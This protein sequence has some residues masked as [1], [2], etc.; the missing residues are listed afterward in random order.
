MHLVAETA[1][2]ADA[3]QQAARIAPNKGAAFDKAAGILFDFIEVDGTDKLLIRSTNLESTFQRSIPLVERS[4]ET[5]APFRLP[6]A[7]LAAFL[8]TLPLGEGHVTEL[9]LDDRNTVEVKSGKTHAKFRTL[10][11]DDFPAFMIEPDFDKLLLVPDFA[12]RVKQVA[13]CVARDTAPLT[14]IHLDGKGMIACDR[15]RAAQVPCAIPLDHPITAPLSVL[16]GA[17]S[18][19]DEVRLTGIGDRLV[20]VSDADTIVT[21][22]IYPEKYPDIDRLWAQTDA[23]DQ[24]VEFDAKEMLSVLSRILTLCRNE[25]YPVMELTFTAEA[26]LLSMDVEDLGMVDDEVPCTTNFTEAFE[27]RFT[28]TNFVDALGA[29]SSST[30]V[31]QRIPTRPIKLF[32]NDGFSTVMMPRRK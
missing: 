21:S 23:C 29:M 26:M 22:T 31:F 3:V 15:S 4:L 10:N 18:A 17:L 30:L 14:G 12:R 9:I 5:P 27:M 25:R 16:S 28:P 19:T 20:I 11:A 32:D 6:S 7:V 1:T 13:W 8:M 2:L 24:R